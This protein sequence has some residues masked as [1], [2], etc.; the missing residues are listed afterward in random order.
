MFSDVRTSAFILLLI[1]A[2]LGLLFR[3]RLKPQK[4]AQE[5]GEDSGRVMQAGTGSI[6]EIKVQN[7]FSESQLPFATQPYTSN[8]YVEPTIPT[9]VTPGPIIFENPYRPQHNGI[10]EDAQNK[11]GSLHSDSTSSFA[12]LLQPSSTTQSSCPPLLPSL[13]FSPPDSNLNRTLLDVDPQ[14]MP[15]VNGK[16]TETIDVVP[17]SDAALPP[18][19]HALFGNLPAPAG[20]APVRVPYDQWRLGL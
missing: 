9:A 6:P 15:I 12:Q 8:H 2:V 7:G 18:N 14:H 13:R 4:S 19:D 17:G 1:F 5:S 3:R 10:D 20:S 16:A 11:T